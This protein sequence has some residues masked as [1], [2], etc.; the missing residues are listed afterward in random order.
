[1]HGDTMKMNENMFFRGVRTR[2]YEEEVE[3]QISLGKS[4]MKVCYV[5]VGRACGKGVAR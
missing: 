4:R 1:M 3:R 2:I 5:R